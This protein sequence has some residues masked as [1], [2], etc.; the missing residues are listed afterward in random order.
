ML[1]KFLGN[2]CAFEEVPKTIVGCHCNLLG[3]QKC[4]E[5]PACGLLSIKAGRIK[6]RRW[7]KRVGA[8]RCDVVDWDPAW[9]VDKSMTI[10]PW[11]AMWF[12]HQTLLL[13]NLAAWDVFFFFALLPR[14]L[15]WYAV[16]GEASIGNFFF[17]AGGLV[18]VDKHLV[19]V[20]SLV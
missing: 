1:L 14:C 13:L 4:I 17:F 20:V 11:L 7:N 5:C 18:G 2:I 6:V 8:K 3:M 10:N 15:S 12:V 9:N 16:L 19:E